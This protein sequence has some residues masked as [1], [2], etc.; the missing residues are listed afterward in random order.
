MRNWIFFIIM[1][2]CSLD[3]TRA[4]VFYQYPY[5]NNLCR[6][7]VCVIFFSSIRQNLI[8]VLYDFKDSI[9]VLACIF[10]YIA[11]FAAIGYFITEGT[12]QGYADFDSYGNTY[13]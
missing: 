7:W 2:V 8:S 10:L 1:I 3:V 13:Y 11:Y 9:I 12:F 6:P 5:V 4:A